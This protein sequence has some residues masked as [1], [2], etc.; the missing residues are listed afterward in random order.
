MQTHLSGHLPYIPNLTVGKTIS[1]L[2][3]SISAGYL[4][5]SSVRH[6]SLRG[7]SIHIMKQFSL[8]Y[9]IKAYVAR[10]IHIHDLIR[11]DTSLLTIIHSS[12]PNQ[13]DLPDL[14]PPT[15]Y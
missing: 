10:D 2:N 1:L 9:F 4:S 15:P 3:W 7:D 8:S 5:T 14:L 13:L 11:D 6:S 12:H